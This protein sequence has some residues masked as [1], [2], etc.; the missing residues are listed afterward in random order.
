M[1]NS[2]SQARRAD[3]LTSVENVKHPMAKVVLT[4]RETAAR[5]LRKAVRR[6]DVKLDEIGDHGQVSRQIDDK[7]N[8]S[9]HHVFAAWPREVWVELIPLLAAE[10]GYEVQRVLK[11]KEST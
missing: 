8:L 9:F 1:G 11:M 2:M 7:E 3:L 10:F 6:S 4:R 5:A